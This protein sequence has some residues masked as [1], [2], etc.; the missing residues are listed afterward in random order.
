[1]ELSLLSLSLPCAFIDIF[2]VQISSD[3]SEVQV[4]TKCQAHVANVWDIGYHVYI[5]LHFEMSDVGYPRY[6]AVSDINKYVT[7]YIL[8]VL[9]NSNFYII[10]H[11][12]NVLNG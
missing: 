7:Y 12:L 5:G 3:A 2:L 8:N 4:L 11:V 10:L 6:I 1:M 9:S